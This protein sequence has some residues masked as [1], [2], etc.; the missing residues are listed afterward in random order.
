MKTYRTLA[1]AAAAWLAAT[2]AQAAYTLPAATV[3][4]GQVSGASTTLL[5]LDHGFADEPGSNTTALAPSDLEF[6]SGDALVAIDFFSDGQVQVWNNSGATGLAGSYSFSFS[7]AGIGLPIA[8]FALLDLSGVNGGSISAQLTG[9]NTISLT[10]NNLSFT[11]EFGSFTTQLSVNA[12][13]EPTSLALAG[14]GLGLLALRRR[15][16]A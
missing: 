1:V 6:L 11:S 7:F 14:A 13:P 12:V 5:G 10:L 8:S 2:S 9:P 15:A 3:I 4:T 16:R